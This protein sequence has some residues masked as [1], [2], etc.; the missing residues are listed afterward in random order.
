MSPTFPTGRESLGNLLRRVVLD[1]VLG[2]PPT[3]RVTPAHIGNKTIDNI[4][5]YLLEVKREYRAISGEEEGGAIYE[6]W[7]DPISKMSHHM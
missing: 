6:A 1:K 2:H 3:V 4:S 7:C 5:I